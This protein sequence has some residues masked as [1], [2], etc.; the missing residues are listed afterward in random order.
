[1][2]RLTLSAP[3]EMLDHMRAG[4]RPW[5]GKQIRELLTTGAAMWIVT[6]LVSHAV[7]DYKYSWP[8]LAAA[9]EGAIPAVVWVAITVHADRDRQGLSRAQRAA[10]ASVIRK[11]RPVTPELAPAVLAYCDE[12]RSDMQRIR[13]WKLWLAGVALAIILLGGGGVLVRAGTLLLLHHAHDAAIRCPI[14][15]TAGSCML[16]SVMIAALRQTRRPPGRI[17]PAERL[18]RAERLARASLGSEAG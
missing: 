1:M 3:I 10:V 6:G 14:L 18:D 12:T 11:G 9:V 7:V 4:R 2:A 15:I 8:W 13:A 16:I 5:N 17:D